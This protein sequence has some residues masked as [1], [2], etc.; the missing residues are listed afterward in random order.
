[1]KMFWKYHLF[2]IKLN[3]GTVQ[4]FWLGWQ[5]PQTV[6]RVTFKNRSLIFLTG[7]CTALPVC[8]RI[9]LEQEKCQW[10]IQLLSFWNGFLSHTVWLLIESKFYLIYC[11]TL[12]LYYNILHVCKHKYQ[13]KNKFNK[14]RIFQKFHRRSRSNMNLE[15]FE[16]CNRPLHN[17]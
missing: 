12:F 3:K 14:E 17:K 16:S 10:F 9:R 2:R 15:C 1:M 5:Q 7:V 8:W 11:N 6:S 4:H 13:C